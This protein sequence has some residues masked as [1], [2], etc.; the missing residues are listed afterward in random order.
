ME[1]SVSTPI[2]QIKNQIKEKFE[3]IY[4][5]VGYIWESYEKFR[6]AANSL[7][8]STRKNR[9]NI[10]DIREIMRKKMQQIQ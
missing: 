10:T 3:L 7:N 4:K 6:F 8:N 9:K 5:E 1:D 2:D